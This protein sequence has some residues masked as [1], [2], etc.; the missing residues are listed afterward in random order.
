[1][2]HAVLATYVFATEVFAAGCGVAPERDALSAVAGYCS[3]LENA[4]AR[5]I[6]GHFEAKEQL[7]LVESTV[8]A[9]MELPDSVRPSWKCQVL[10]AVRIS[11]GFQIDVTIVSQLGSEEVRSRRT[12]YLTRDG[13]IRFDPIF[14]QHPGIGVPSI[15]RKL[16]SND[17]LTRVAMTNTARKIGLPLQGYDPWALELERAKVLSSLRAWWRAS[18]GSLGTGCALSPTDRQLAERALNERAYN[19]RLEWT[20]PSSSARSTGDRSRLH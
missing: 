14:V 8:R 16:E 10:D 11:C 5:R 19:E 4:D 20:W 6:L 3:A 1:M 18:D 7:D 12:V 15:L 13:E 2:K 17:S 9:F